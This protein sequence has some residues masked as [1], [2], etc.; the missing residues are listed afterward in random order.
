MHRQWLFLIIASLTAAP[1]LMSQ[2]RLTE[3]TGPTSGQVV[4]SAA[5]REEIP[6]AA[7]EELARRVQEMV[8]NDEIVG[9]ELLII[10]KRD[11]L[12]Q[13]A[14]G[15]KDVESKQRLEVDAVYCVRSMTKPLV[16][17]AIQMLIDEGRLGLDT[18][19]STILPIFKRPETA[20]ITVEQLLTHTAGFPFTTLSKALIDYP[21]LAAV[22]AEATTKLIF[23]PGTRFEYS[24]AG[25]DTLGAIVAKLTGAPAEA[26]IQKRI[27]D[28]LGMEDTFPLLGNNPQL[29]R[30]IPSAYSGGTGSWTKHW[31]PTNPAIFPIFLTSQS[32]YTTTSDY[33]RV[34]ALWLD[35]GRF[36][37]QNLLSPEAITRA[38]APAQRMEHYPSQFGDLDLFY[39][40]QWMVH[41]QALDNGTWQLRLFGHDGSDGTHAWAWPELDLMVLF[42]T[43]SRGT[44]AGLAL[45][46][47]L[48]KL[49]VEQQTD[50]PA[51]PVPASS[52]E[53][54][55]PLAGLYWDETA[56]Q[57]YYVVT[58]H[59]YRLRVL[60]PG[61]MYELFKPDKVP[62]RF[63]HEGRSDLWIEFVRNQEGRVSAMR[64]SFQGQIELNPRHVPQDDLPT[65]QEV[66]SKVKK[67]H[68]V[69]HLSDL[70]V[71][72]MSGSFDFKDRGMTGPV[73]IQ[74][75]ANHERTEFEIGTMHEVLLKNHD[76]VWT[77]STSG[78]NTELTGSQR[79]QALLDH[80]SVRFGDWSEHYR[81]VEV[82]KR[83]KAGSKSLLLV[84]VVPFDAPG[85][86]MYVN[87]SSGIV[88]IC[89]SIAQVPGVGTIGL[90]T[91]YQDFRDVG[92]M[93][94]PVQ[95][96]SKF[97]SKILGRM[98]VTLD[99]TETGVEVS[100]TTFSAPRP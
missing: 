30:R 58:P 12:F 63:V 49:L 91:H 94:L 86:T 2:Q 6:A 75:D 56:I 37:D 81:E 52:S 96:T 98:V 34:L 7:L 54:L 27:L 4:E 3:E 36:G 84:R 68:Q 9:G 46:D 48:Q 59:E 45:Q 18:P 88:Q 71:V 31:Q 62:G 89:D 22:A 53:E 83:L 85:A 55:E 32:L 41:A 1:L 20:K 43:Q 23:E 5:N 26:F 82:L 69:Q 24:D 11:T 8:D 66:I 79:E 99:K 57:A 13:R 17:T 19:V 77:L 74:F 93:L 29:R 76:R 100:S 73:V 72:R 16:G 44:L 61:R 21:D 28:P 67:A 78:G 90:V 15:W 92:G 35:K 50:Q 70:G 60:R 38:L 87:E 14:F 39:G 51:L 95:I 65:V 10:K 40:Q 33:A 25:S 42:F 97:A 47:A 80:F 64:S